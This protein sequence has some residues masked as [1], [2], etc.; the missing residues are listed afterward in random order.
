[1]DPGTIIAVVQITGEVTLTLG[2]YIKRTKD[3]KDEVLKI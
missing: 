3:A 1:M 2:R